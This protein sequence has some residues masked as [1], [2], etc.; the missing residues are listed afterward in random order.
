MRRMIIVLT[1]V[2]VLSGLVLALADTVFQP[3]IQANKHRA[4]QTSLAAIFPKATK[5]QFKQLPI[6]KMTIYR[7][8]D[9]SGTL[10]GYAVGIVTNG[11]GGPISLLIGLSAD[12]KK[13]VG[14][15]VVEDSETPGM[16]ARIADDWFRNQFDGLNPLQ[17]ITY[18][19]NEKPDSAKNQ[20]EA[21]SGATISTKAV[22]SGL[23]SSIGEA[24][25]LIKASSGQQESNK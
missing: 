12:L 5:P 17:T 19:K 11:Y 21:I 1:S 2:M 9:A 13:I 3:Q 15:E 23:N 18:V 14:M 25:S 7:G 6:K 22:L 8:T 24:V 4:L 20:I 10:L 16:G